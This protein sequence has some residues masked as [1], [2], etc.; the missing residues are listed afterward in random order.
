MERLQQL[1]KVLAAAQRVL[2]AR[3]YEMLT[4]LE[5][6]SLETAV[7]EAAVED[8]TG[9]SENVPV[10]VVFEDGMILVW[11]EDGDGIDCHEIGATDQ[12][13]SR[14][15]RQIDRL[16]RKYKFDVADVKRQLSDYIREM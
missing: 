2:E 12:A 5:W 13:Q 4:H 14:A 10:Q 7:Y 6:D 11:D 8:V 1:E 3:E 16:S 9:P 15:D